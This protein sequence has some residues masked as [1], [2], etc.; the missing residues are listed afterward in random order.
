VPLRSTREG[1][2]LSP[3]YDHGRSCKIAV[4]RQFCEPRRSGSPTRSVCVHSR[5]RSISCAG[6]WRLSLAPPTRST[7]SACALEL[8]EIDIDLRQGPPLALA[9]RGAKTVG[10]AKRAF[11]SK[12]L[13]YCVARSTS[14]SSTTCS[15]TCR[16]IACAMSPRLWRR[17]DHLRAR[18]IA[19]TS[20]YRA[21]RLSRCS[22]RAATV[23]AA[24]TRSRG[25]TG[26][27]I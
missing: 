7:S 5:G 18:T 14:R 9:D 6:R 12:T 16:P 21:G 19:V 11:W 3:A 20:S 24:A 1:A 22:I 13:R 23:A 15:R 25:H 26:L 8:M 2:A 10:A 17:R 27:E 4:C